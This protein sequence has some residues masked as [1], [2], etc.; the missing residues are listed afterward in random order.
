MKEDVV[1]VNEKKVLR[2]INMSEFLFLCFWSIMLFTKGMGLYD[3]Q[4]IYNVLFVGAFF[5]LGLKF[6]FTEH[7]LLEWMMI[8]LLNFFAIIVYMHSKEKGVLIF[9][10]VLTSMKNVSVKRLC[11]WGTLVWGMSMGGIIAYSLVNF[12]QVRNGIQHKT[13]IGYVCRY[14]M[15]YPHPNTLHISY[16]FLVALIVYVLGNRFNWKTVSILTCGNI[17]LFLYSFSLTGVIVAEILILLSYYVVLKKKLN[18]LEY[19]L[20]Q[21]FYP[22][23]LMISILIPITMKGRWTDFL[24][25][26]FNYRFELSKKYLVMDNITMF[27]VDVG[28]LT[29]TMRAIDN[30]F[31][32]CLLSYGTILF[33]AISIGYICLVFHYV[34]N[35]RNLELVICISIWLGGIIEPYLFNTSFKNITLIFLGNYLFEVTKSNKNVI[36]NKKIAVWQDKEIAIDIEFLNII[37]NKIAELKKE[38]NRNKIF[39]SIILGLIIA[40]IYVMNYQIRDDILE[41]KSLGI[42]IFEYIRVFST[43]CII[44]GI[45]LYVLL[46]LG[47]SLVKKKK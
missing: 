22:L 21:I 38:N 24:N 18:K 41:V 11:G 19:G 36:W 44:G 8:I 4:L 6:L 5:F 35:K 23:C 16:L 42:I 28:N 40:L 12:E 34:K 9:M 14:F 46:I 31:I 32:N 25:N 33:I 45:G 47:Y 29:S 2:T 26:L 10:A 13:I 15:G 37:Q 30:S 3:G 1:L 27:G 7:T 39:V 43:V 17:F 20:I